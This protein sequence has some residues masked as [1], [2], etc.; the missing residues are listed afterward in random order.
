MDAIKS[1]PILNFHDNQ[2]AIVRKNYGYEDVNKLV[3]DIDHFQDW[4]SKQNHFKVKEFDR[5]FLERYI[6]YNK[7]SIERAKQRFDKLLTF[8]TLMPDYLQ[9]FDIKNEFKALRNI[10]HICV[11]PKPTDDNYRVIITSLTGQDDD[12]FQLISYYRYMFVLGEYMLHNDYCCGYEFVGDTNNFTM[13]TVKKMN[14]IVIHK[15][16]TLL[17][18][19]M[20]QRMKK[21]HL[22]S[23]SKFFDTILLLFKQGLSAKLASRL[24]VHPNYESLYQHIPKEMLPSNMG[25]NERSMQELDGVVFKEMCSDVHIANVKHMEQASTDESCRVSSKFN[26]EYSGMPGSFKTLCVDYMEE[27]K[28][29]PVLL[30]NPNQ[31]RNVRKQL[32]Y[33]EVNKLIQDIDH[34]DNW[35]RQQTH[36]RVKDFDREFLER[37]LI[38]NKGS[39]GRAKQ[40]FDKLCTFN[41]LMPEL[42]Q[43]YDIKNEFGVTLKVADVCVLPQPVAE[44]YRILVTR[45]TGYDDSNY[46]HISYFRYLH[47]LIQYMLRNDYCVGYE[48]LV[49]TRKLTLST[50]KSINPMATHKGMTLLTAGLGQRIKKIH[51]MSGSKFFNAVVAIGRQS[52]SAKLFQRIIIHDSLESLYEH[53]PKEQLPVDFGGLEKSTKE[54]SDQMFR[55][56]SS[57]ENIERV[58]YLEK[59]S[60]NESYRMSCKFNEEYSGMPGSFKTLCVD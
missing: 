52:I 17:V 31:L 33:E 45:L 9:N 51:L 18:E 2:L 43:N 50:M 38:Y 14:P 6:I 60:T 28:K 16:L 58:K 54:L 56:I 59:A 23:G 41:N 15:A 13:G 7:G 42:M 57:E 1:N 19:A 30:F 26:E 40:K 10:S 46:I 29:N 24:I 8:T 53:I 32:N 35:I 34:L 36:F 55:E 44:N 11:L 25:G 3:Q 27:I 37:F 21:L 20:G 5:Q 49:D 39:I 12:D 4:I 47:L 48:L 22:V